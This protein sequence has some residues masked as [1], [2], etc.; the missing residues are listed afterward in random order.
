MASTNRATPGLPSPGAAT[1]LA[2]LGA[3]L[4]NVPIGRAVAGPREVRAGAHTGPIDGHQTVPAA[5][6][7]HGGVVK[8]VLDGGGSPITR[9]DPDGGPDPAERPSRPLS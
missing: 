2:R 9:L 1:G 3:A 8:Q 4:G 7:H 6:G 5:A